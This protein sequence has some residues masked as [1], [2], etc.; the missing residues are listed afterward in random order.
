MLSASLREQIEETLDKPKEKPKQKQVI[1][2]RKTRIDLSIPSEQ[3]K[4]WENL[5]QSNG[6]TLTR[7]IQC[8]IEVTKKCMEEKLVELTPMGIV[9]SKR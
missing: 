8:S 2:G 5:A 4:D 1:S 6:L 3:K 9:F 7:L